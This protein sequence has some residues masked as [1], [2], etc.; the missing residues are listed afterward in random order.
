MKRAGASERGVP[1][2]TMGED[3]TQ[4]VA[5]APDGRWIGSM[6]CFVSE[7]SPG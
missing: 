4:V 1:V 5:I 7:G 2:A 3:S 6:V